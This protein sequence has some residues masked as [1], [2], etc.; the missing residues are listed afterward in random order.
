MLLELGES[1]L[2]RPLTQGLCVVITASY[3]MA[4]CLSELPPWYSGNKNVLVVPLTRL[5]LKQV[6]FLC[7]RFLC[8]NGAK[9]SS[10]GC[11]EDSRS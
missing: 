3:R 2:Y 7:C 4:T 8:K 1:Y 11:L 5:N 10:L 9:L 6:L